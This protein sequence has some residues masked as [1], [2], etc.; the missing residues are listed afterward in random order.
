MS[1]AL[2]AGLGGITVN[3]SCSGGGG[4]GSGTGTVESVGL[5]LPLDDT[6]TVSGSPVTT[7]GTLTGTA[8]DAGADS[9]VGW[10]ES[11]GKKV[12]FS[13][14]DG[15]TI[16]GTVLS[17]TGGGAPNGRIDG[18]GTILF[19]DRIDTVTPIGEGRWIVKSSVDFGDTGGEPNFSVTATAKGVTHIPGTI[20]ATNY[21]GLATASPT[22]DS[23]NVIYDELRGNIWATDVAYGSGSA[24][25]RIRIY[26]RDNDTWTTILMPDDWPIL[27]LQGATILAADFTNRVV[28]VQVAGENAFNGFR[29]TLIYDLDTFDLLYNTWDFPSHG[30]SANHFI[31]GHDTANST[32]LIHGDTNPT[33]AYNTVSGIPDAHIANNAAG[34]QA[35]KYAI[36]DEDGQ[37]W[38]VID[39]GFPQDFRKFTL[40]AGPTLNTAVVDAGTD[41][42]DAYGFTHDIT[43][44]DIVFFT[45]DTLNLKRLNMTLETVSTINA[46]PYAALTGINFATTISSSTGLIMS[47]DDSHIIVIRGGTA[48]T[49]DTYI[50]DAADGSID[51]HTRHTETFTETAG[52]SNIARTVGAA[53]TLGSYRIIELNF[54]GADTGSDL[55]VLKPLIAHAWPISNDEALVE[56]FKT[57]NST[58]RVNAPFNIQFMTTGTSGGGGSPTPADDNE[59]VLAFAF[60]D[61]S[62]AVIGSIAANKQI[63]SVQLFI[64]QAFNGSGAALQVGISGTPG[65]LMATSENAP[66]TVGE[67]SVYTLKSYGSVTNLILTITPGSGASAGTG[68]VVIKYEP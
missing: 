8:V 56:I 52:T 48:N 60:G 19:N 58:V 3:L 2:P 55:I 30:Q 49:R 46:S 53:F 10:D 44:N 18:D 62:P 50:V 38:F 47:S 16:T 41:G 22:R 17:A 4:G 12:Y 27:F 35:N 64:T 25:D 5:A 61:A 21:F 24:N 40:A 59:H 23:S 67:Y 14:G 57:G 20:L 42:I 31:I 32:M 54:A 1:Y 39:A 9:L 29:A 51:Q 6:I 33:M 65:D 28:Y 63:L 15:L 13:I 45:A 26:N 37:Y 43:N 7:T 11:A 34:I 66:G 36:T 68:L